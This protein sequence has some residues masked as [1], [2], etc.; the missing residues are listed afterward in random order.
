MRTSGGGRDHW[1]TAVPLAV[2]L[3]F[4]LVAAGGPNKLLIKIERG[5]ATVVSWVT[6][7]VS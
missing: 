3:L 1:M 5:L 2:L 4:C 6:G 7:S